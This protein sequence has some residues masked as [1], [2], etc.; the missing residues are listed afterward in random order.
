M[1]VTAARLP[2]HYIDLVTDALLKVYWYKGSLRKTLRRVGV[3]ER[4]LATWAQEE[5]KRDFLDRL[6]PELEGSE[7]GHRLIHRLADSLAEQTSFPDLEQLEDSGLKMEQAKR[8]VAS[9]RQYRQQQ[10]EG[11]QQARDREQ[12]RARGRELRQEAQARGLRLETLQ[13]RLNALATRLGTQAAGYEFER[14]FYDLL[15]YY[16]VENRR[17]YK[18]EGRQI[19][20][21]VTI[22]GT[23]YLNE[24][25]FTREQSDAP[26]ID[27]FRS[28]VLSKADNTMGILV[29]M[30]GFS[31]VAIQEAS[32]DKTPLLLLDYNHLYL[33]FTGSLSFSQLVGRVRRHSS[34]T[35]KAYLA[36]QEF[37][38]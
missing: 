19:D 26:D 5:T 15:D 13:E 8:S 37:G 29:S 30:S 21:S 27:I 11:A 14:W 20:G 35:G 22:E 9:L 23:T 36:V 38:G 32:R 16:E 6:L 25:K 3:S 12:S 18:V 33:L 1:G 17:P 24:L 28:K 34:Q 2:A 10:A 31:S 7:A 4:F